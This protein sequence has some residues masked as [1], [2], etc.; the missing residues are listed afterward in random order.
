[1][2]NEKLGKCYSVHA[3]C[4]KFYVYFKAT[5]EQIGSKIYQINKNRK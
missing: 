1:M 3:N 4:S 2:E 5:S